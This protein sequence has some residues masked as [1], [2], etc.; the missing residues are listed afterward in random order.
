MGILEALQAFPGIVKSGVK[1]IAKSV[2]KGSVTAAKAVGGFAQDFGEGF[3]RGGE[4]IADTTA[5]V[6]YPAVKD[7]VVSSL[8]YQILTNDW[9]GLMKNPLFWLGAGAVLLMAYNVSK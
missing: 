5:N 4:I 6:I 2:G 9:S 7:V 1:G 3:I 8:P